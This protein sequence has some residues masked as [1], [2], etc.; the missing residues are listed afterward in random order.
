MFF[1]KGC[2]LQSQHQAESNKRKPRKKPQVRQ[3]EATENPKLLRQL[4]ALSITLLL[5]APDR[6]QPDNLVPPHQLFKLPE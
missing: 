2:V 1:K 3:G 4:V 6:K 5:D